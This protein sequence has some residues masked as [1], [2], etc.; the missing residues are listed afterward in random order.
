MNAAQFY[1]DVVAFAMASMCGGV[2]I[3][4]ILRVARAVEQILLKAT[5]RCAKLFGVG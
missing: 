3:L 1:T 2:G 4:V 5:R